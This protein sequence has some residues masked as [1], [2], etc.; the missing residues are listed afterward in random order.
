[1]NLHLHVKARGRYWVFPSV[2]LYALRHKLK[3]KL[4]DA[5]KWLTKGYPVVTLYH[6]DPAALVLQDRPLHI[7]QF[8]GSSAST[9][10][11]LGLQVHVATP[12]LFLYWLLGI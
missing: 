8:Q 2:I 1:M 9:F 11:A 5:A 7:L 3:L 12:G 10:T 6:G 4:T